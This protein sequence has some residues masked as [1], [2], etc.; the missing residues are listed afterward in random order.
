MKGISIMKRKHIL[1]SALSILVL[2]TLS[3]G[4]LGKT[5][6]TIEPTKA[7]VPTKAPAPTKVPEPTKPPEPTKEPEPTEASTSDVELGE[8][9]RSEDGGFS[10]RAVP[11]YTTEEAYGMA[12]MEA[13]GADPDLGP[14]MMLMGALGE[15]SYTPEE[16]FA[17]F[18]GNLDTNVEV[19]PPRKIDVDGQP[20]VIADVTGTEGDAEM[21]GRIVVAAPTPNHHFIMVAV[22]PA[23]QWDEIGP[24]FDA[25][26]AS[27]RFFEPSGG[28][29]EVVVTMAGQLRQWAVS[30][31]ASSQYGDTGWSADQATGAPDTL[32]C[33]DYTTAWATEDYDTIEWI[34]LDYD[35]PV[36]PLGVNIYQS[37]NPN[38][39][40][41]VELRDLEGNYYTI[42]TGI[43]QNESDDC[44][45]VL[46]ISVDGVLEQVD[47][48]RITIDQSVFEDWVEIDAVEL[49][50]FQ[51]E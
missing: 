5:E 4:F 48:V 42:Y 49:V 15:E 36:V 1:I 12:S 17:E 9:V 20:G 13:P 40:V 27:V 32:D 25:V 43:P 7:P 11:G 10:F 21:V 46:S 38:Q 28:G 51:I 39:V 37:Y 19:S 31:T 22:A 41:E 18:T 44:P 33:G 3:C 47:G 8:E 26:L 14:A 23:D 30:A 24:L 16:F 45:F 29:G 34:E 2:V 6:P 35:T 50:G